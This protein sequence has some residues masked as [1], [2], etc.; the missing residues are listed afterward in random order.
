MALKLQA[1]LNRQEERANRHNASE[2]ATSTSRQAAKRQDDQD[3]DIRWVYP[4][5]STKPN[6]PKVT[7][8]LQ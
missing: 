8:W 1:E 3:E 4:K 7:R 6:P 5:P 2:E